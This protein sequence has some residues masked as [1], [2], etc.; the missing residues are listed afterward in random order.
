MDANLQKV[1]SEGEMGCCI[2]PGIYYI[3]R[4]IQI[5][6]PSYGVYSFSCLPG[7]VF[8]L[9]DGVDLFDLSLL[10]PTDDVVAGPLFVILEGSG[11]IAN[12]NTMQLTVRELI[13]SAP[14]SI[15][16]ASFTGLATVDRQIWKAQGQ[17]P[18]FLL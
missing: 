10:S 13:A 2:T 9:K 14:S 15:S 7:A 16:P 3:D 8:R 1:V 4:P 6:A 18:N 11:K 5:P 12:E 17:T